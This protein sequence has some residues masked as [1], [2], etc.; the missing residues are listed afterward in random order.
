MMKVCANSV[1]SS[2]SIYYL[3]IITSAILNY[4]LLS[5][6][7]KYYL[8]LDIKPVVFANSIISTASFL[9]SLGFS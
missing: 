7:L 4:S 5:S 6:L 9:C 8:F 3:D 2:S 1:K